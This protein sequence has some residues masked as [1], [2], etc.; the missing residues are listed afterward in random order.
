MV[1]C[2]LQFV[3]NLH[4]GHDCVA[5]LED[6]FSQVASFSLLWRKQEVDVKKTQANTWAWL[7]LIRNKILYSLACYVIKIS[8]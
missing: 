3:C 8:P 5:W 2:K 6:V 4:H 1:D 7:A